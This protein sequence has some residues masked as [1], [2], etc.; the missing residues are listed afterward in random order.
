VVEGS[1]TGSAP[2]LT[3]LSSVSAA[4]LRL[5]TATCVM[6]RDGV[7]RCLEGAGICAGTR[8]C[9]PTAPAPRG[10][11]DCRSREFPGF[12]WWP[13][14]NACVADADHPAFS[15]D[16]QGC[17]SHWVEVDPSSQLWRL[18]WPGRAPAAGTRRLAF[19]V[20]P[21]MD[22]EDLPLIDGTR[23]P[24]GRCTSADDREGCVRKLCTHWSTLSYAQQ[25]RGRVEDLA[26]GHAPGAFWANGFR[27]QPAH[28]STCA[29]PGSVLAWNG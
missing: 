5:G 2:I 24:Y 26:R 17:T 1:R 23:P 9:V 10:A 4:G 8:G 21:W 27:S 13:A 7:E 14:A 12:S 20:R 3:P 15:C 25:V 29:S 22:T 19:A 18:W 11:Q 16:A 28:A 6:Q